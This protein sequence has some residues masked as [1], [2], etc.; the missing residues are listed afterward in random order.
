MAVKNRNND[1]KSGIVYIFTN[2]AMPDIVKIGMTTREQIDDRLKELFTTSVPVPFECEYACKVDDCQKV[3]NALHIA[4]GPS[5]INPQREFFKIEPE[6]AI[7]I[8]ELFS[9]GNIA[10]E[11]SKEAGAGIDQ[12]A[13]EAGKKLKIQRRPH[14]NFNEMNIPIDSIIKFTSEDNNIEVRV[15]SDKKVDYNGEQASLTRATREILGLNYD[16]QPTPYWTFNGRSLTDI[17][18]DTYQSI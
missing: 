8:L 16:V 4:F 1:V 12:V 10:D 2:P 3:E 11:I 7:A 18:N 15:C 17:Y 9:K 13:F 5:R 14:L 6:Q